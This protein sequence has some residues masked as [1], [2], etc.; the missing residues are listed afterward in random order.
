MTKPIYP[1]DT[2]NFFLADVRDGLGPYLAVFL[3]VQQHWDEASIGIVMTIMGLGTVLAQTP[4]GAFIDATR[5]KRGIVVV[6]TATVVLSC[7]IITLVPA[8]WNVAACK[9]AMG[10]CAAV[11]PPA[12]AAITLGITGLFRGVPRPRCKRGRR[13]AAVL[14]RDAGDAVTGGEGAGI[15]W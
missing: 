3:L 4:V 14:A 11:F 2:L 8:F 10:I 12:V 1:L 5:F 13:A 7:V 9:A 15:F 6:A